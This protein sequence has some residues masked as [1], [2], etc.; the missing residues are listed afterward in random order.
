M[1]YYLIRFSRQF[2]LDLDTEKHNLLPL[3]D[4]LSIGQAD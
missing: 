3:E 1:E 2:Q 4:E